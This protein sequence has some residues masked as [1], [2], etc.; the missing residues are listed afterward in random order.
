[1]ALYVPRVV[2]IP[3]RR[4]RR[5]IT[6]SVK[7]ESRTVS[8]DYVR[9]GLHK[10]DKKQV[11]QRKLLQT[12]CSRIRLIEEIF[13]GLPSEMYLEVLSFWKG[14]STVFCGSCSVNRFS[15]QL[16]YQEHSLIPPLHLPPLIAGVL[17]TLLSLITCSG[18]ISAAKP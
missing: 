12:K 16:S 1:M 10:G 17:F 11:I 7:A 6:P 8:E 3:R 9:M 5:W 2:L 14:V 4:Q 15:S 18:A 13:K